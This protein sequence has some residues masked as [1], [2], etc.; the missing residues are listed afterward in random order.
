MLTAVQVA[1]EVFGWGESTFHT[2]LPTLK[3][4]GFP[5]PDPIIGKY[6]GKAVEHWLD[7]RSKLVGNEAI[8]D[9]DHWKQAAQNGRDRAR[10]RSQGQ[11]AA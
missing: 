8:I 7:V 9:R 5:D 10:R 11:K 2:K 3:K 1:H 6:D 4:L